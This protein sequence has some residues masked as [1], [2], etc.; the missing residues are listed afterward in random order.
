MTDKEGIH[1]AYNR[2]DGWNTSQTKLWRVPVYTSA[3][4]VPFGVSPV[5]NKDTLTCV[6][7]EFY[8]VVTTC[9][10][11]LQRASSVDKK[12]QKS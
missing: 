4:D 7:F 12:K 2:I 9:T 11:S 8:K 6:E 10:D 5:N 3:A 1:A